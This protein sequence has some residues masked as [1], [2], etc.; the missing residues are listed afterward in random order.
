MMKN[1]FGEVVEEPKVEAVTIVDGELVETEKESNERNENAVGNLVEQTQ[2]KYALAKEQDDE[3]KDFL[4][5]TLTDG[6]H[7]GVIP[8]T[9]KRSLFKAGAE[10]IQ[11]MLGLSPKFDQMYSIVDFTQENPL[12]YYQFK[13]TLT[14]EGKVIAEGVGACNTREDKYTAQLKYGR[15]GATLSNTVLKI[16]KKRAFVDAIITVANVSDLFTQDMLDEEEKAIAL[17]R[18]DK[19]AKAG[20]ASRGQVKII[21]ATLGARELRKV[22]LDNILLELGYTSIKELLAKDVDKVISG[23]DKIY[24]DRKQQSKGETI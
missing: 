1:L 9:K 19:T 7:Y 17:L 22:D 3:F 15:D 24:Q 20:I 16:A 18:A 4:L 21:F 14:K 6:V 11:M 10:R 8:G 5:Q 13:C 12:F 2:N 23:I